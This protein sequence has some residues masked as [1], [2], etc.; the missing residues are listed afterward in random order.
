MPNINNKNR[1]RNQIHVYIYSVMSAPLTKTHPTPALNML[2]LSPST[3][4]HRHTVFH[5]LRETL[6]LSG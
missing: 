3:N 2:C 4:P 6:N 5:R 1:A